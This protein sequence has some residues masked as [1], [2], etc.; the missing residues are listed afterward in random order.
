VRVRFDRQQYFPEGWEL[1]VE[2]FLALFQ[3]FGY[4]YKPLMGGSWLSAEE[5]WKLTDSEILKAIA[6]AHPRF[7]IGC[8]AG[9]ASR[10]LVLDI[11]ANS[12]YH[13]QKSLSR[14][15]KALADA[16]LTK[17][18]LYRSSF[19][20]GWH[21]YIFFDEPISSTDLRKQMTA[22][23]LLNDFEI[24]KGTLEIFPHY[25]ETSQ[26][27]GLRLPLQPGF[28]WLDKETLDVDHDRS[29]LGAAQALELFI[30]ALDGDA[31]SY[32]DFRRLKEYLTEL[33]GRRESVS[34][35]VN[36][37]AGGNVVPL[38]KRQQKAQAGDFVQFVTAVFRKLPPG[39]S[40]ETWYRG[41]L[42]HLNGLSA[43][44]QRADAIFTLGHYLFYGD[45][46]RQLPAMG[47]GYEKEREWA[48]K[49]FLELHHNGQSKDINK[50]RSDALQQVERAA[51]WMPPHRQGQQQKYKSE[52]PIAW[53]RENEN[54]KRDARTRIT[55]ALDGLKK[56]KRSFTTVELQEAAGC[57]RRTL[58]DHGD[59]W[60][61][62]YEDLAEGFF[63][64]CT[65]EYNAVEGA[66]SPESLPPSTAAAKIAPPGLLAAR[67]IVFEITQRSD[68]DR[69][70]KH[71]DAIRSLEASESEWR[72]KVN[73][74]TEKPPSSLSVQV[75]KALL[76]VL[77]S[78]RSLAPTEE[79]LLF[80]QAY[81]QSINHSLSQA[82]EVPL[83]IVHPP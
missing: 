14:M 72:G 23:L 28:A 5:R 82:A 29:D 19:S 22:L 80:I 20:G 4:I 46:S 58:Y 25:S 8:R 10:F 76:S 9:K 33:K 75:Q 59:I 68:R 83:R 67:R 43:P 45:P 47:Y 49:E 69:K 26:G 39:I 7:F 60:R 16:G 21:L 81:I 73:R 62:D 12:K 79:D 37:S 51:H 36:K 2:Q 17:C 50:G 56:M 44:S 55:A 30:D 74:L 34:I 61:K 77:F 31:H 52:R 1:C 65:D 32:A 24:A 78:Y 3:R 41:R 38:R 63:A 40:T 6:C 53:I 54:R 70:K 42:Y 64:I 35:A 27:L 71:K 48:I 66:A 15:L 13:N 11:D 18:S 57:S